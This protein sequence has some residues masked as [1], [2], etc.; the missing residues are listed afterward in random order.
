[1]KLAPPTDLTVPD[2]GSQTFRGI[3]S[4]ALRRLLRDLL[5]LRPPGM[6]PETQRALDEAR[7]RW[8]SL[9]SS[10][11][12]ALAAAVQSPGVGALVRCLRLRPRVE[13]GRVDGLVK[14]LVANVYAELAAIDG[15]L[16]PV[17]LEVLPPYVI[18][19]RTGL[20]WD[21]EGARCAVFSRHG[22]DVEPNP[23]DP[24][25]PVRVLHPVVDG[26]T[27]ACADDNPISLEEAHP[28]K[29]GNALALG[30][31]QPEVWTTALGEAF[32]LIS[33]YLP[34]LA[35]EMRLALRRVVPVGYDEHTH[36]SASYQ[37][38]IG[39]AYMSLHPNLMTM[40]EAL[41][42]EFSHNKLYALFE[43]DRGLDNA[44]SP[45]FSSPVRPDPRPLH[46]I[47]LAVHAFL[48]VERLY[49]NMDAD[50]HAMTKDPGFARR[51][52]RIRAG[53][54]EGAGV[55]LENARATPVGQGLL[56]EIARL[57][58]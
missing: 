40:A 28:D 44:F 51:R 4:L 42:H 58:A 33:R 32:N 46:G 3:Y 37:E 12:G 47:L 7:N 21:L 15:L 25:E 17:R 45:L 18:C 35:D 39:T 24:V 54:R 27:L 26:I 5:S 34:A 11:P 50:G 14:Q 36:L 19:Q 49:E 48:P 55:L 8:R 2:E 22:I 23:V 1:M 10:N 38:A 6:A 43:L 52:E 56:D 30:G 29:E 13:P 53:N 57:I 9:A 41:I 20:L 31:K 16:G